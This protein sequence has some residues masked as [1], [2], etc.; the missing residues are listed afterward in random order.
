M[1]ANGAVQSIESGGRERVERESR[2]RARGA[3]TL[4]VSS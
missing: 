3:R 1:R 2:E 4:T